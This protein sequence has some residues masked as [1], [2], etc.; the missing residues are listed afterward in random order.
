[1]NAHGQYWSVV[2]D[3]CCG[4]RGGASE[5]FLGRGL[6]WAGLQSNQ[7][8]HTTASWWSEIPTLAAGS[9]SVATVWSDSRDNRQLDQVY[10]SVLDQ[11][12][13]S[14]L[15]NRRVSTGRNAKNP[16]VA[17][18][19]QSYVIVWQEG[20]A[21][22]DAEYNIW[23][24]TYDELGNQTR[25]PQS[26]LTS[27]EGSQRPQVIAWPGDDADLLIAWE[28]VM[29]IPNESRAQRVVW[30]MKLNLDGTMVG[31]STQLDLVADFPQ[32]RI[33]GMVWPHHL[34]LA[35]NADSVIA[36]WESDHSGDQEVYARSI[37]LGDVLGPIHNLSA[38]P[39][40]SIHPKIRSRGDGFVVMWSDDRSGLP[41]MM[42]VDLSADGI[43]ADEPRLFPTP[44]QRA[45]RADFLS[46][47]DDQ[48]IIL[49]EGESTMDPADSPERRKVYAVEMTCGD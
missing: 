10:L 29:V 1:M 19:N 33:D 41:Q 16:H 23:W 26:L 15:T 6:D 2:S 32:P 13:V 42:Q 3:D 36:V 45:Y 24:A 37:G 46:T 4:F 30:A 8:Q 14:L 31:V 17:Y 5:I 40:K 22:N 11:Q 34:K 27:N 28:G 44:N 7:V 49:F 43:P 18:V 38:D 25:A 9:S 39:H 35:A 20:V 48:Y 12:G 21:N 47:G